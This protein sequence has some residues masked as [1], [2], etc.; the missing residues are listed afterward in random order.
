MLKL[1][2][3]PKDESVTVTITGQTYNHSTSEYHDLATYTSGDDFAP[4]S[5][6]RFLIDC[7]DGTASARYVVNVKEWEPIITPRE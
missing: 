2:V 7:T 5:V 6:D 3:S 1:V 4:G